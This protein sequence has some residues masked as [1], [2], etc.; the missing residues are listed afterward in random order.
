MKL[1]DAG[2]IKKTTLGALQW[3]LDVHLYVVKPVLRGH[4]WDKEIHVVVL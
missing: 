3:E 2:E 4:I 1:L